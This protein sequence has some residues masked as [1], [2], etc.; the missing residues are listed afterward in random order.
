MSL[1][2]TL[3]VNP[4]TAGAERSARAFAMAALP[5]AGIALAALLLLLR[6]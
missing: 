5:L 6:R 2:R 1:D 4:R 3:A